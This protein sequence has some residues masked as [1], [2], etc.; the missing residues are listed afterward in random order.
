[1]FA[2]PAGSDFADLIPAGAIS[3]VFAAAGWVRLRIEG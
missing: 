3:L 1:V 2:V